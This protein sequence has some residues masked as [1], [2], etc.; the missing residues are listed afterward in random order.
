MK[1]SEEKIG[2]RSEEIR[3]RKDSKGEE[4]KENKGRTKGTGEERKGKYVI[5][6]LEE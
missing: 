1:R 5:G 3:E 4:E 6:K 2:V